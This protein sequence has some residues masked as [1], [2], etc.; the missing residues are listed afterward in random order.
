MFETV[1]E[2]PW[3]D[4]LG[5]VGVA[6]Y[7]GSYFGLQAGIIKG[8]GYLYAALNI[9]AAGCVLTSLA[10]AFN[11]SSAIIQITYIGISFFGIVRFYLMTRA[12]KFTEEEQE[13][14]DV[15]APTLPRYK[16]RQLLDLGVWIDA[17]PGTVLAE[18]GKTVSQLSF[19]LSGNADVTVSDRT[20]ASIDARSLIGEMSFLTG[21][22]A[23]ASV[24][25]TEPSRLFAIDIE[26]LNGFLRKNDD[27]RQELAG[28]CAAQVSNKLTRANTVLS[29]K[30]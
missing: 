24:H 5:L 25:V 6:V 7:I 8:Q 27:V 12:I 29:A 14:L 28:R 1:M 22:P 18:E 30:A 9:V 2:V 26:K 19:K 16:S 15:V 20:V 11:L 17:M 3:S 4:V 10:D 21:N 23:S 13:F